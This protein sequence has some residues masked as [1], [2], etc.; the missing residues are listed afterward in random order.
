MNRQLLM[1][2]LSALAVWLLFL[3]GCLVGAGLSTQAGVQPM[4][5]DEWLN[6]NSHLFRN[7]H[8]HT[9][10]ELQWSEETRKKGI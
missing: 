8:P 10:P 1:R 7:H 6:K 3:A 5:I 9:H 2:I 4:D